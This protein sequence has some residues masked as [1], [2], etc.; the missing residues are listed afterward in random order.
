MDAS[1]NIDL[2]PDPLL[3]AR[4]AAAQTIAEE[5]VG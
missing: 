1:I 3:A 5:L 4:P 2:E